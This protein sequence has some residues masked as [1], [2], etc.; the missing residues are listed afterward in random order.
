M[1][2]SL[3]RILLGCAIWLS[4]ATASVALEIDCSGPEPVWSVSEP[5]VN[6]THV[7]C[8][9]INRRGRPV[10]FHARPNGDDPPNARLIEVL[11]GPN[12]LGVYTAEVAV[13]RPAT[14]WQTA[15]EKFSSFFPDSMTPQQIL[16]AILTAFHEARDGEGKWRGDPGFGFLIEGWLLPDGRRI[17]TAWPIYLEDR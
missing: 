10:G 11:D 3:G 15:D 17:N 1:P 7:F 9:E 8:G 4:A 6:L 5:P 13:R 12:A 2:P 16:D 14:G